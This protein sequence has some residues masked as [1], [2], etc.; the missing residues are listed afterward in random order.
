VSGASDFLEVLF[1]S[2]EAVASATC[3]V[4]LLEVANKWALLSKYIMQIYF[5]DSTK[6]ERTHKC[7]RENHFRK[8]REKIANIS[9]FKELLDD[10]ISYDTRRTT[11]GHRLL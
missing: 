11:Q 10:L 5:L 8:D 6:I 2:F 7:I 9:D 3:V 1:L 4:G